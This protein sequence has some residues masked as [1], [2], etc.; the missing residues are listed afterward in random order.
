MNN[1]TETITTNI[2]SRVNQNT[3]CVKILNIEK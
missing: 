1:A 3:V 2:Y